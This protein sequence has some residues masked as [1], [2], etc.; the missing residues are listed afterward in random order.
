MT[1]GRNA[2]RWAAEHE[3]TLR[4]EAVAENTQSDVH[5]H[6]KRWI[7]GNHILMRLLQIY[8]TSIF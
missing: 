3:C 5:T 4:K 8:I 1:H 7:K 2:E 6:F